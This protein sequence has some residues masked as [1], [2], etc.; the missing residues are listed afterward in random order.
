MSGGG[1]RG[2]GYTLF[3]SSSDSLLALHRRHRGSRADRMEPNPSADAPAALRMHLVGANASARGI[4][5]EAL[6]GKSNYLIGK[7]RTKWR[8]DV[9]N[10][11]RVRYRGVYP[12]IDLG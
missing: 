7:D 12:G 5:E 10:Y 6:P 3:L 8:T 9:P 4:A 1:G 11:G 2:R